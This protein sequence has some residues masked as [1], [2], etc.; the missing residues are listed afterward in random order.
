MMYMMNKQLSVYLSNYLVDVDIGKVFVKAL[1]QG[2]ICSAL[3][4]TDG[5]CTWDRS[6][7]TVTTPEDT[8]LERQKVIKDAALYKDEYSAQVSTKERQKKQEY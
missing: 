6:N 3:N 5:T 4:H 2:E 7:K 8:E 1:I